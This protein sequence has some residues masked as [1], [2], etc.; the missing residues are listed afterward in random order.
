MLF[1]TF[2]GRRIGIVFD[3]VHVRVINSLA[4]GEL[5][6]A[7]ELIEVKLHQNNKTVFNGYKTI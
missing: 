6:S 4:S 5:I 2:S 7:Y 1:R 3:G